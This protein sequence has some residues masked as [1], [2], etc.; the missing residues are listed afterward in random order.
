VRPGVDV[1][2][3]GPI[4]KILKPGSS[5]NAETAERILALG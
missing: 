4:S 2:V 5:I 3:T 1:V